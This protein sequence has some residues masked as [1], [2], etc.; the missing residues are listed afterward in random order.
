MRLGN[1]CVVMLNEIYVSGQVFVL[2]YQ[3]LFMQ[4]NRTHI[5][6]ILILEPHTPNFSKMSYLVK[7]NNK[8]WCQQEIRFCSKGR[9]LHVASFSFF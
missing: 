4:G 1:T 3:K 5:M 2:E 6:C 8:P 9:V 7:T